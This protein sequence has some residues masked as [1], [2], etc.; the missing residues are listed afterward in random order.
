MKCHNQFSDFR[1]PVQRIVKIG[2]LQSVISHVREFDGPGDGHDKDRPKRVS[3]PKPGLCPC[4]DLRPKQRGSGFLYVA[5]K[6]LGTSFIDFFQLRKDVVR[7]AVHEERGEENLLGIP[8]GEDIDMLLGQVIRAMGAPRSP[9]RWIY[10][11]DQR[12]GVHQTR[13]T[14]NLLTV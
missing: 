4:D 9:A 2:S 1:T 8:N 11:S 12:I 13:F 14:A 5:K 3:M 10:R 7:A 6:Y